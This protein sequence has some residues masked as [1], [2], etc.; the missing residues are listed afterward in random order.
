MPVIGRRRAPSLFLYLSLFSNISSRS[1]PALS[2]KKKKYTRTYSV[3]WSSVHDLEITRNKSICLPLDGNAKCQH[4]VLD[5]LQLQLAIG[6]WFL[7]WDLFF[8]LLC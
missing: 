4:S 2:R 5:D 1:S 6:E 7:H 3:G 8:P